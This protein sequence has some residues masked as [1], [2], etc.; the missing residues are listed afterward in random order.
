M[1]S[2]V[3]KNLNKR[4]IVLYRRFKAKLM[5]IIISTNIPETEKDKNYTQT[6]MKREKKSMK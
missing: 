4:Q 1:I 5:N 2:N 3:K 6:F